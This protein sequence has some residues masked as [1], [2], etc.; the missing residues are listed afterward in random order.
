MHSS[1]RSRRSQRT[2]A[3]AAARFRATVLAVTWALG[4]AT[5]ASAAAGNEGAARLEEIV[6]TAARRPESALRS[7]ASIGRI[8]AEAIAI[9]GSTHHAEILN[10]V[11][12]TLIQRGSGEE[13]LTAI[14]S[15]VLTGAGS[16]GAF[17][18]LENGIPIRPVGVC[19]VNEMFEINTEQAESIEVVRGPAT[20]LYGSNALHGT[21]NVLQPL[22]AE[23]ARSALAV[24]A[25]PDS[26]RRVKL[27][28]HLQSERAST[29]LA[30][31]YTHDG[32]WRDSSGFD[33]AKANATLATRIAATPLRID[34][35]GTMLDQQ[36]AGFI[37]GEDAYRDEALAR[38]NP[39]PNAYRK[40]HALRLTGLVTPPADGPMR[41]ELRPYLRSSRME[42]LQHFLLGQ[43]TE[44]NGQES[45]GLMTTLVRDT[46]EG[47]FLAAGIDL[48][49][50]DSFLLEN[51]DGPTTDGS[52][53][54]NAIRPAGRHYDY[55]VASSVV[56]AYVLAER[57]LAGRW[58]LRVGLR[59]EYVEYDY[60]NRMLAGNTDENGIPC[61]PD[62]CLYSRPADRSDS[63]DD[64]A[65]KLAL[66]YDLSERLT[67][68]V[69]ASRGFRPPETT[70]LYRLQRAQNVADLDSERLDAI[71]VGLKGEFE[72][73]RFSL[74]AFDMDKRNVILREANGFNV[75]NGR[76]SHEGVEYEFM[77]QVTPS[78]ALTAAGTFARHRYEFSRAVEGG[79]TIVSGN[80]V[81]T[82]PREL[83]TARLD[84]RPGERVSA[85]AEWLMV[86][87]YWLD[88]AN[89]HRYPGHDLVN[90]RGRY[91]FAAG[92]S[93]AMRLN[94]V[95]DRV[96]ADRADFAFG[97]FRYFSG[98]ERT[99]FVEL[100][101]QR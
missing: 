7:A 62:G 40:A 68:Y 67:A 31:L 63:F 82:A 89:A 42:F 23:R 72:A 43:P 75:S 61:L 65:P 69:A 79:E 37:T 45:L 93:L 60:D 11:P 50:A 95:F 14:R 20:S 98:R 85:E 26:Y 59:A 16:C 49:Y 29:G 53:A 41:L 52:P 48:E 5:N 56:A 46:A 36:T 3:A 35:A 9:T 97:N 100:S 4:S 77:W 86:G 64:L 10:R 58:M 83:H 33:E 30:A 8:G 91:D 19:N 25:G 6:V 51:Q 39:D 96:Y 88:A 38:S 2:R 18:F 17:L 99:L 47:G 80:D 87:D 55:E 21:I 94:N 78:F 74:A 81:D 32:G 66:S 24:D 76:T 54:A 44:R 92:W 84:W 22:P 90:L 73:A 13:S 28:G 15:P 34:L 71:E 70:E 101:W 27:A 1:R 12:G 57:R